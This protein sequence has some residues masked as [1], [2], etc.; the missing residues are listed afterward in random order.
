MPRRAGSS[1]NHVSTVAG[2]RPEVKP[3][4]ASVAARRAHHILPQALL[5]VWRVRPCCL[6]PCGRLRV[7]VAQQ[8]L[9]VL[10]DRRHLGLHSGV[11][12]RHP[13]IRTCGYRRIQDHIRRQSGRVRL[14]AQRFH[15]VAAMSS[16]TS[17]TS[18]HRSSLRPKPHSRQPNLDWRLATRNRLPS[19][20]RSTMSFEP[21]DIRN[22]RSFGFLSILGAGPSLGTRSTVQATS[23]GSA[24]KCRPSVRRS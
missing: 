19:C 16:S 2:K 4:T 24:L 3:R 11:Q 5:G 20:R 18:S 8:I 1:A 14:L 7:R 6:V 9:R 23:A 15:R 13:A 10:A 21:V 17:T 22:P 12:G